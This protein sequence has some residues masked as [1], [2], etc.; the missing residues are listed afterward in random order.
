MFRFFLFVVLLV[1]CL[2]P[3]AVFA[4]G[5][6]P[7]GSFTCKVGWINEPVV[8]GQFNG[9]DLSITEKDD[10]SKGVPGAEA[11]LKFEIIYGGVKKIFPLRPLRDQPG[12]YTTDIL[13]TRAGQYTFRFFGTL[14]GEAI[15]VSL[16]PEEVAAASAVEFPEASNV[17]NVTAALQS[18]AQMAQTL[19]VVGI[20][21]GLIGIGVG[22]WAVRRR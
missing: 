2:T 10:S 4:H 8:V 20:G 11:T 3:S 14:N 15:E 18:Q 6:E 21:L 22:G 1:V 19:A 9:L 16:E 17:A 5:D 13:P 7:C 12:H